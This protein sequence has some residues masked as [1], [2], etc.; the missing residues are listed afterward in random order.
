M[1]FL[2]DFGFDKFA[3]LFFADMSMN[4]GGLSQSSTTPALSGMDK[5]EPRLLSLMMNGGV[6][7]DIMDKFGD[8]GLTTCALFKNI[9]P[10]ADDSRAML[11]GPAFDL[12]AVDFP[13]KVKIGKV[14]T[15][16]EAVQSTVAVAAKADAERIRQHLPPEVLMEE[17]D[18][19]IKI[20]EGTVTKLTR[21]NMPSKGL[22]ERMI[23]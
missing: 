16:W 7:E 3:G 20:F 1:D 17:V 14:V 19:A 22:Y 11:R 8:N 2:F 13:T 9:V 10:E 21:G 6:D 12:S 15:V 4:L 5:L 18:L 23:L